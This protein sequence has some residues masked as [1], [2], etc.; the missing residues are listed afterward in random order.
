MKIVINYIATD[1]YV[2]FFDMFRDTIGNF[3]PGVK[4]IVRILTN[5]SRDFGISNEDVERIDVIKIFDLVYP[6]RSPLSPRLLK[7]APACLWG[8][9]RMEPSLQGILRSW[10]SPR[11]ESRPP[12]PKVFPPL[13]CAFRV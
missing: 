6:C 13:H 11:R 5:V 2:D 10:S 1:G 8:G 12:I 7:D 3:F 4:K 9:R